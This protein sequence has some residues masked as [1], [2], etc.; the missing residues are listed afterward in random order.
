MLFVP[1]RLKQRI[2]YQPL[3][4]VFLKTL[5][6]KGIFGGANENRPPNDCLVSAAF[7]ESVSAISVGS[8]QRDRIHGRPTMTARSRALI[9][10]F[11]LIQAA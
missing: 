8:D 5:R 6:F 4:T 1:L 3:W 7:L 2:V 10:G 9:L 11:E